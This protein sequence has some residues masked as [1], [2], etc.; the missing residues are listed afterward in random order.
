MHAVNICTNGQV[1]A[2]A[3]SVRRRGAEYV[4]TVMVL[5]LSVRRT[6]L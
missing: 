4:E 5:V 1:T 6:N 2:I 3:I